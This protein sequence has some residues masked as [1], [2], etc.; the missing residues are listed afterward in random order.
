MNSQEKLAAEVGTEQASES[1]QA[2]YEAAMDAA[3]R[4]LHSGEVAK[5]TVQRVI[6]AEDPAQGVARA[7]FVLLRRVE[8]QMGGL[9]DA[10]KIEIAEDLVE[11]ILSL[12]VE[13]ERMTEADVSDEL[14]AKVVENLYTMYAEDAEGRGQLNAQGVREDVDEGSRIA[15]VEKP[16]GFAAMSNQEAQTRGLMD[17]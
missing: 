14:I 15:G 2:Q 16:Q 5:K 1:E 13:T 4:A 7:V 12:M 3:M 9:E 17:V 6:N 10:V 11:E 8:E